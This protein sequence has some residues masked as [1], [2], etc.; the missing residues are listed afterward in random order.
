VVRYVVACGIAAVL[1]SVLARDPGCGGVDSPSG[2]VNAP[3]TRDKD[4][5]DPLVCREGVCVPLDAGAPS[6]AGDA[7]SKDAARDGA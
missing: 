7:A 6:D 3:C 1:G 5:S 2:S 4:C